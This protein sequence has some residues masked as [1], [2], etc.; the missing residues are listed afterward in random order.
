MNENS[1]TISLREYK[2]WYGRLA[3]WLIKDICSYSVNVE[4]IYVYY[5]QTKSKS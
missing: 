2:S 3:N 4:N 1:W 5:E